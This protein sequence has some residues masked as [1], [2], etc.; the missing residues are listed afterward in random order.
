MESDVK[1]FWSCAAKEYRETAYKFTDTN[2][3][4]PF[5]EVRLN[6]VKGM[7]KGREPDRLLDAGCGG[8]V[9]LAEFLKDGWDAHGC[10]LVDEMVTLA[11]ENLTLGGHDPNRIKQAAIW[12]LDAYP[13]KSFDVVMSLGVMEYIRP[14]E[15][16][17]AFAAIRRVLRD[18]G[19]F[20]VEN[21][22]GLFDIATFN[23][24]TMDFFAEHFFPKFFTP[25]TAAVLRGRLEKLVTHP[26]KP[27]R[28]GRFTTTRDQVFTKA[29]NPLVYKD[30]A[31]E[32]GF[33]EREQ[34]F[35]RFH[36]VPPLMFE[37]SPELERVSIPHELELS[38]HW[39]GHFL[40]SGFVSVLVKS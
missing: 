7:L 11:K 26:D 22:N 12:N 27:S 21:I 3:R 13:D 32:N 16:R 10:D 20:V 14:D 36:A 5:Y 30:K 4:Y 34:A 24:F 9:V 28:A 18:D 6:L 15:E 40:A 35:Y 1:K 17:Q 19:I 29:E 33:I 37:E 25:E 2:T 8:A 39:I 23:R 38:R 31:K